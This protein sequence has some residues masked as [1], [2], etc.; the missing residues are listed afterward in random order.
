[1]G[2]LHEGH[3]AL[4]RLAREGMDAT[5]ASI[6]V[7]PI[8]FNDATDFDRYP[9]T[10]ARDLEQ[11]QAENVDLVF[12]PHADEMTEGL[13]AFVDCGGPALGFEGARR[14]GHFRG[15]CTIVA[16]LFQ[17]VQ[18]DVAVF[19]QKDLQQCAVLWR[20]VEDLAWPL[21]L[22]MAPTYREPSGLA[23]SSRNQ[24]L[25]SQGRIHAA[26]IHRVLLGAADRMRQTPFLTVLQDGRQELRDLGFDVEYLDCV[27]FPE[28]EAIA[29]ASPDA[30][31][32][33]AAGYEGVRLI[34]NLK[35]EA[36]SP[37]E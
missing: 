37:S 31:L 22:K 16:K 15:V 30:F 7:N 34:D 11:L 5:A 3:L 23:F 19:G 10:E 29:H 12:M 27:R 2:A 20:M 1:M 14:P 24:R 9:R 32:I 4:M 6:Y 26:H 21:Q 35:V 8:Q 13:A 17:I 25:S 33:V 18:P 28:F 36:A